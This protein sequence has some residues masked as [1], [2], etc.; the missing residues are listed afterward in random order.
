LKNGDIIMVS[1]SRLVKSNTFGQESTQMN[2]VYCIA[3]NSDI[4][5]GVLKGAW[6]MLKHYNIAAGMTNS[7]LEPLRALIK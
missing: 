4:P 1:P 7:Q 3:L 6:E 2:I 5:L